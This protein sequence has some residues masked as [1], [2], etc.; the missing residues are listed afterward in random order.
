MYHGQRARSIRLRNKKCLNWFHKVVI[1]V[2]S[3]KMLPK[4]IWVAAGC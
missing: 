2:I 3:P 4:N 1:G